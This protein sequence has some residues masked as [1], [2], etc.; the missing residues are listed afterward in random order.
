[1]KNKKIEK[2]KIPQHIAIILDGNGRWAKKRHMP[3]TF[4][5]SAG[6][7]NIRK[8]TLVASDLGIKALSVYTFSTENW[9]RPKSEVD[10]LMKL[11]GE[12]EK[13]IED[14]FK[15]Y[16]VKVTF[17]GRKNHISK[18]NMEILNRIT[19]NTKNRKGIILN[20]CFDYGSH[21]EI[22]EAV[23]HIA[24]DVLNDKLKPEE[25]EPKHIEQ[26]LYT[27]DLP[28][29][30]LLIRTSGE[31]RLSNFLLWQV[32]Y[33]ELY[34]CE[35]YWPAFSKRDLKK[36]IIEYNHRNRRFGGLKK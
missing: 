6:V 34:F 24:T 10:Y 16:D 3:R 29:L 17:S 27:K 2:L 11:L 28:K 33:A 31:I 22:T 19:K 30:D 1:M 18:E 4:G 26:Y 13:K 25:I 20:I 12:F 8:I 21:I 5:H 9:S 23:K 7:E 35:T 36:A 14:D 32:A 15:K